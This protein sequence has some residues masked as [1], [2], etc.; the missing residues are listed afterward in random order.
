MGILLLQEREYLKEEGPDIVILLAL[1]VRVVL[2]YPLSIFLRTPLV[3]TVGP[4]HYHRASLGLGMNC[5][6]P[7]VNLQKILYIY[8]ILG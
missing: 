1:S 7:I 5:C 4:N 3:V 6:Q 2:T 8:I